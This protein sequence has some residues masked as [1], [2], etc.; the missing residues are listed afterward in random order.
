[1]RLRVAKQ[2]KSIAERLGINQQNDIFGASSAPQGGFAGDVTMQEDLDKFGITADD[3]D[4]SKLSRIE[5]D[6]ME[7]DPN[8]QAYKIPYNNIDGTPNG[9]SRTRILP[10]QGDVGDGTFLRPMPGTTRIYFPTDFNSFSGRTSVLTSTTESGGTSTA[11]ITPLI[12]VDDERMAAHIRKVWGYQAVAIQGPNGWKYGGQLHHLAEG[13]SDLC[14]YIIGTES[15]VILWIGDGTQRTVQTQVASFAMEFKFKGVAFTHIRQMTA[16]KFS[17]F[18]VDSCLEPLSLFPRHPNIRGFISGKMLSGQKLQRRDHQEIALSIMADLESTGHRIRST[19]TGNLY[20]FS[21]LKKELISASI[22][23]GSRE[24]MENTEFMAEIYRRYGLSGS[25]KGVLQWLSTFFVSEQPILNS[26]S[27][28]MML[29]A[30]RKELT[31]AYQISDSHFACLRE[32]QT[33]CDILENGDNGILFEKG[34]VQPMDPQKVAAEIIK[35]RKEKVLP[36]WWKEIIDEMRMNR[37]KEFKTLLALLYYVSPWLKGWRGMQLPIEVVTGEAGTGK[38]SV[39]ELRLNI[40]NGNAKLKGLPDSVKEWHTEVVNTTGMIVFDNVH[41]ANKMHRQ[42]LSDEMCRIVTEPTPTISMRK[43]YKTA[44]LAEMPV[45]CTFAL[46]SIQNVFTNIDFIDRAIIVGLERPYVEGGAVKFVPWVEKK[47]AERGGREA[48]VA[49]HIVALERFFDMVE[50]KWSDTYQSKVRLINFEQSMMLMAKVFGIDARWLPEKLYQ[51]TR[52]SAV[53]L[54]WTLEGISKFAAYRKSLKGARNKKGELQPFTAGEL[55]NWADA[56][57]VFCRNKT[58]TN[59]RTFN[60]YVL[61]HKTII[62]QTTGV[63]VTEIEGKG[64]F[65]VIDEKVKLNA[66]KSS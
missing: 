42:A 48:W 46:T 22:A 59:A 51:I 61:S 6:A 5:L 36:M 60:K 34:S 45:R 64:T 29:S 32:G 10:K 3:L 1:M 25:D 62:Q 66:D 52:V 17:H 38:S 2:P 18:A 16:R 40:M 26:T 14:E 13:F 33:E 11:P 55:E 35:A 12:V 44:E 23:Q 43:L 56:H 8:T 58:L 65:Y 63:T 15:V 9:F 30:T 37:D 53:E 7:L 19:S 4:A 57:E 47:L 31:F 27:Y 21:N 54:D 41:L 20:Y 39:F 24:L 49:H 28:R 50:L